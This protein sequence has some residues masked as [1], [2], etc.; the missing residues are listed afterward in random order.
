MIGREDDAGR[1]L[2]S[3]LLEE[4][5]AM[6]LDARHAAV[7]LR[8]R[9]ADTRKRRRVTLA[10]AASVVTAVAVIVAGNWLGIKRAGDP[11]QN[12]GQSVAVAREFLDAIGRFDADTA[13]S[14]LT[15]DAS[16]T[17]DFI[18][19]GSDAAEQI[20]LTLAHDRAEGY[21]QMIKD[22]VQV[23]TSVPGW[24]VAGPSVSCAFDMQSMRS[25]EIGLDT[26]T[27]NVWRLTVRD[28]KIV[29]AHQAIPYA[30]PHGFLD[31]VFVPFNSWMSINHPND[32]LT[33]YV[34]E[35]ESAVRYT[36][37]ANRLWE[38]R[39]AEYVA[40]VTQ[41]PA[42][43]L[44]QPK[45][46]AYVAKLDSICAAAQARVKNKT[47]AIPQQ[48]Q[49]AIFEARNR[50]MLKTIFDLR[51]L[52]LPDAVRW[53]YQGRAFPLMEQFYSYPYNVQPSESLQRQIQQIPGLDKCIFPV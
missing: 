25:G 12:P 51:A 2:R 7:Q 22:C 19:E 44:D 35:N 5:S 30:A 20:R 1:A 24:M 37:D 13:I 10:V 8:R 9:I 23:G 38:Q 39:T 21:K 52:P 15:E 4:T 50:D 45:I 18:A 43:Y 29:W 27:G 41:N 31:Q 28:G 14:Y 47:R 53:S 11:A 26:Y 34:D 3:L 6:P 33:M 32:M 17:G 40:A 42:A 49:T 16:V 46:A 48:N 36:E